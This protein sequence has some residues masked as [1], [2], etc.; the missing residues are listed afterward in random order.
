MSTWR[1]GAERPGTVDE[2][3]AE[4]MAEIAQS[5]ELPRQVKAYLTNGGGS[6]GGSTGKIGGVANRDAD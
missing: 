1:R 3:Y 4:L 5:G 2:V 6:N